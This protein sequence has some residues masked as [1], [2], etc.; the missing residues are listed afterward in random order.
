MDKYTLSALIALLLIV[1]CS[2]AAPITVDDDGPAHFA[3]IQAA[4]NSASDG[5]VIVVQPGTYGEQVIFNGRRVTVR[6]SNPD[7]P[8]VVRET[9]ITS[10]SGASVVFDFGED[11]R[12]VLQGFTITGHGIYC[13]ASAPTISG[14]VIQNCAEKGIL[15]ERGAS[16]AITGNTIVSN[17]S[18]GIY[19]CDGLIQGN[20]ILQ[21]SAGIAY[22]DGLISGNVIS[23]NSDASGLYFCEGEIAGNVIVGNVSARQ[24]GG[25][26]NC[27]GWIHN[28]IIA[29]N[30]AERAG[31]GLYA[32]IG[33]IC[34][35][36]IVENVAG[37]SGGGLGL[38]PGQ[39]CGNIIASNTA[40][41]AGGIHGRCASTYNTFWFNA[42]GNLGGNAIVGIGDTVANPLFV[43]D[44]AWDDNGTPDTS[45]DTWVG[46]DYHLKSQA[47]RWDL[48]AG[49]WVTDTVT[50]PCIDA[51]DPVSD[52]SVELWPHGMRVNNGV[53][54]GTPE[55]SM[56]TSDLGSLADLNN[57]GYIGLHDLGRLAEKWLFLEDLLAEDLNRDGAVDF[58]DF[59]IM[60]FSWRYGLATPHPPTPETMTWA[61]K[62][63]A[64]GTST[65][66]MVAT[67]AVSTDGTTVQ[68]YFEDFHNPQF[69]SGWLTFPAGQEARWEDTELP[70]LS[71]VSYRVKARNRGNQLETEWSE[72][73]SA[74]T[75]AEDSTAP[76]PSPST[77][78]E[79]PRAVSATTIRMVATT[80]TDVSGVEDQFECT[81]H[82]S[83]SSGWQDSRT[84]EVTSLPHGQYT[85]RTQ[86]RDKSANRNATTFSVQ[87][88]AD[89]QPP[90]PDPMQWEVEPY[91][92]NAMEKDFTFHA[93]MVA[94]QATDDMTE[95]EYLFEC[96]TQPGFSSGWQTSR[97]YSVLVG[98]TAQYHQFR[99]KA[100]DT[101]SGHNETG[102]S[103]ELRAEP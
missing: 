68:Y 6:S 102:W 48:A 66:A 14:N 52:W 56:S 85:F 61:V 29:G 96:T 88:T 3:T 36:T 46:G 65:I 30:T 55:A 40:P 23:G 4:I 33:S 41:V 34:N 49:R 50:S 98:R 47:G 92:T 10:R 24:G 60:A 21:N 19:S 32:C 16:P 15:G 58:N 93:T 80:A 39:I 86:A 62:P 100:R 28:N 103:S 87:V 69:N 75:G 77:W 95:V 26:F 63:Y 78:E 17:T 27:G 54:G 73:A 84:Y 20:T 11:S 9:V 8:I 51:G 81:S 37:D 90:T 97:E 31:G 74:R 101:S 79:Q 7:D 57:D 38:C 1:P 67:T 5:D 45:D 71:T 94:A 91:E 22:C 12:S 89:L 72:V 18:E 70:P 83:R 43:Q 76:T 59:G 35:N 53:Y 44:G 13:A 99:V 25:L 64:I 42:G 2:A 82:P